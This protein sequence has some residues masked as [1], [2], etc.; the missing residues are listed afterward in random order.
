MSTT[1]IEFTFEATPAIGKLAAR[2]YIQR[3]IGP[4]LVLLTALA[5]G[6][7]VAASMGYQP[8]YVIVGL[9]ISYGTLF[10]WFQYYSHSD[11]NFRDMD[12]PRVTI[13]LTDDHMEVEMEGRFSRWQWRRIQRVMRFPDVWLFLTY[14]D[15]P[16]VPIPAE[17][18]TTAAQDLIEDGVIK[19]GGTIN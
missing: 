17:L 4:G 10:R 9:T 16:Y 14:Q 2:R 11:A 12:D 3:V 19:S 8:W 6:C 7:T 5:I 13:R 18:L 15:G 1:P